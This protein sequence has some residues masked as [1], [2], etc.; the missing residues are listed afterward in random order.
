M[1]KK[2][3]RKRRGTDWIISVHKDPDPRLVAQIAEEYGLHAAYERWGWLGERT[4][5]TLVAQGI[6]ELAA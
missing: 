1:A 4:I 2:A 6:R 5:S 3:P